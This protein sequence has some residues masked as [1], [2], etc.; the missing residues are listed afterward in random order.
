MGYPS[1]A[2]NCAC[3][4]PSTLPFHYVIARNAPAMH[5]ALHSKS[6]TL[7][8]RSN[9]R[10]FKFYSATWVTT[11]SYSYGLCCARC[12]LR[13]YLPSPVSG[14]SLT[15]TRSRI[16]LQSIKL[17]PFLRIFRILSLNYAY[18]SCPPFSS[19][20]KHHIRKYKVHKFIISFD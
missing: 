3:A 9:G 4:L 14:C 11:I 1:Y 8:G 7:Y 5:L 15:G 2:P 18:T 6:S 20:S 10:K 19:E 13:Y 12:E 17:H 16:L